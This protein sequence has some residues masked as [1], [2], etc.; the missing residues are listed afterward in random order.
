[1]HPTIRDRLSA[2]LLATAAQT[3][4]DLPGES[5]QF[6][7]LGRR[8]RTSAILPPWRVP[9]CGRGSVL[10]RLLSSDPVH[11][12]CDEHSRTRQN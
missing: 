11:H 9:M 3:L 2:Q 6:V 7:S 4:P 5:G 8:Q 1:M 12:D 10:F